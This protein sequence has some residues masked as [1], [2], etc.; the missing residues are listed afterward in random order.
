MP[1]VWSQRDYLGQLGVNLAKL[2]FLHLAK[3]KPL[4]LHLAKV[5]L[6]FLH[7]AKAKPLFLHW[8]KLLF[9]ILIL[10]FD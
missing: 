6:L 3:A 9:Y 10:K 7:L 8:V 1:G 4:F 2:L 5:K